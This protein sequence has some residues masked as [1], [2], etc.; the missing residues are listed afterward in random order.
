M[1]IAFDAAARVAFATATTSTL[2]FTCSGSN[3]ILIAQV[4]TVGSGDVVTGVTFNSIAMTRLSTDYFATVGVRVYIYYL[5]A[6]AATTANIVASYSGSTTGNIDAVSYTGAKQS[7]PV[8]FAAQQTAAATTWTQSLTT[9]DDNSWVLAGMTESLGRAATAGA[10]TIVRVDGAGQGDH[11]VDS[12]GAV[13]PAGSRAL[14]ISSWL[15]ASSTAVDSIM[16]AIPPF[17]AAAT[18][19]ASFLKLLV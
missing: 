2:S 12:N 14:N 17:V 8:T 13:S 16:V 9:V 6:P 15:G 11:I 19:N 7:A 10:N 18:T 4:N 1:A 3:R 5:V